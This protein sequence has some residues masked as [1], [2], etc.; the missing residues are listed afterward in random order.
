MLRNR[1]LNAQNTRDPTGFKSGAAKHKSVT[2]DEIG[3]PRPKRAA[4]GE[5]TEVGIYYGY[6][7]SSGVL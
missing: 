6:C 1:D 5:I 7:E 3:P 4:I 2:D